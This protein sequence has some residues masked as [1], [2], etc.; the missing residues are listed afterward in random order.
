MKLIMTDDNGNVQ[1]LEFSRI[2]DSTT[3]LMLEVFAKCITLQRRKART[4]GEAYRSQGYMGNVARVLS[5]ASRLKNMVWT[6][7]TFQTEDS[8]ETVM[9]TMYDL[10]NLASFFIINYMDRNKWGHHD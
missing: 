6:D 4:Y 9:D 10:I 2:G 3:A 8:E 7:G 5:K 1:E